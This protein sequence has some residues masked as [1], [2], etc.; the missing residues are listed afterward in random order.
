M[1][2]LKHTPI[3]GEPE[4]LLD[5]LV[6]VTAPNASP[7]TFTGTRTYILGDTELAIIDPGPNDPNHLDA[8]L[9]VVAG[10]K[11]SHI[12]ITHNHIDHS[13]LARTLSKFVNASVYA[14]GSA[15]AARMPIMNML[16]DIGGGEGID[17][18]FTWDE[19]LRDGEKIFGAG[20]TLEVIHTPGHLSN[21]LCFAWL[22]QNHLFSGDHVMSWASTLISPPDG[23]LTAFMSSLR[24]LQSRS[25]NVYYPGHGAPLENAQEMLQYL[26]DHRAGREGQIISLLENGPKTVTEITAQMYKD[27][28]KNLHF[29]AARNVLAHLIDLYEREIIISIGEFT[30]NAQFELVK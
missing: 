8:I 21:H 2:N 3:I 14:F 16:D 13:P 28:D 25:E 17:E 12:L 9:H 4:K 6:V 15:H 30:Q 10:R 29:A 5:G 7:M 11:V 22:E 23:D 18:E 20:W 19:T 27:I 24:K 1:F 26:L